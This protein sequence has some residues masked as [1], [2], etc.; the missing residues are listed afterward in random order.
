MNN[1]LKEL[2]I[3]NGSL[4]SAEYSRVTF[5]EKASEEERS[6]VRLALERYC[7]LDTRVT[8]DIVEMLKK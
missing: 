4:G 5:N 3:N 2:E 1:K 6:K 8:I 7:H